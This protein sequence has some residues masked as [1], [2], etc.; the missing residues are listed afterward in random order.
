M[1]ALHFDHKLIGIICSI[2][3]IPV[4]FLGIFFIF[5]YENK[6]EQHTSQK[7][8]AIIETIQHQY[9]LEQEK[10]QSSAYQLIQNQKFE[11]FFL[12]PQK[13]HNTSLLLLS[14]KSQ[15][16]IITLISPTGKI[17]QHSHSLNRMSVNTRQLV[18]KYGLEKRQ[19]L[20]FIEQLLPKENLDSPIKTYLSISLIYPFQKDGKF[21]G[22]ILFRQIL[23]PQIS[24]LG[25]L[26]KKLPV[27]LGAYWGNKLQLTTNFSIQEQFRKMPPHIYK[28]VILEGNRSQQ[29]QFGA[30]GY[31]LA[32]LPILSPENKPI[33]AWFVYHRGI[34][35]V[36]NRVSVMVST[37][38]IILIALLIT[39]FCFVWIKQGFFPYLRII[40]QGH[41]SIEKEDFNHR[42]PVVDN[43]RLGE[44]AYTFNLMTQKVEI[45]IRDDVA[46]KIVLENALEQLEQQVDSIFRYIDQGYLLFG[47]SF[48][49][50]KGASSSCYTL[51]GHNITYENVISLFFPS[52]GQKRDREIFQEHLQ[53]CFRNPK[54]F[55]KLSVQLPKQIEIK[56]RKFSLRYLYIPP[57]ERFQKISRGEIAIVIVEITRRVNLERHFRDNKEISNLT[58]QVVKDPQLFFDFY[59]MTHE[60]LEEWQKLPNLE[61]ENIFIGHTLSEV[62]YV[63]GALSY[64]GLHQPAKELKDVEKLLKNIQTGKRVMNISRIRQAVE[65]IQYA[66]NAWIKKLGGLD[67]LYLFFDD[68]LKSQK[69]NQQKQIFNR[70]ENSVFWFSIRFQK[71]IK[72]S[73]IKN[74]SLKIPIEYLK[75]L[76][77]K[78][79]GIIKNLI[80]YAAEDDFFLGELSCH[81]EHTSYAEIDLNIYKKRKLLVFQFLID[82]HYSSDLKNLEKGLEGLLKIIETFSGALQI[83]STTET[84]TQFLIQ[85]PEIA[86]EVPQPVIEKTEENSK[87]VRV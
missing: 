8:N 46:H 50:K 74:K 19:S 24:F 28:Q 6:L 65:D 32:Y 14:R 69:F 38:M 66:Q 78:F 85:L 10:I 9:N 79:S 73:I 35:I 45:F 86:Q 47:S 77:P 36:E 25:D 5:F 67:K 13:R 56:K 80:F 30:H 62:E 26:T 4:L 71:E 49:I 83:A 3:F 2:V 23:F 39:S 64:Y 17:L 15:F 68:Y 72:F 12:S 34:H 76:F 48:F 44:I 75:K 84:G 87:S 55:S 51:F 63:G 27:E 61:L 37:I 21:Y 16:D 81:I 58:S 54:N 52:V 70:L 59:K 11:S 43:E 57:E 20:V 1:K 82:S 18:Q 33:G 42:I 40:I 7:V 41:S 31:F 60:K 53:D 29:Y 22:V